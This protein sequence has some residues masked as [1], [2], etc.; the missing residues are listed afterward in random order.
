MPINCFITIPVYRCPER[1]KVP[2][3]NTFS[4]LLRIT[5]RYEL[6][7]VRSQLLEAIRD[8]Y[9]E[10]F[11]G[12]APS[13]SLGE[14]VFSGPTPHPNAVL[15][16]FVQQKVT[17]ALPMA[18]YMATR[19]GLDSLMDR[20]L[21]QS[22]TLSPEI[23]QS[24]IRGF[25]ALC[26]IELKETHRLIFGSKTTHSCSSLKCPS[27]RTA[28]PRGSEAH[29]K[30]VDQITDFSRSGTRVLQVL[31]LADICGDDCGGFCEGCV[32]GWEAEHG[33]VRR[34]VWTALPDV[35]GLTD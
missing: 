31:S 25:T 34:K 13:K 17:S 32:E 15:N 35:F 8:A 33:E 28:G 11:E 18:Y 1:N 19:R 27:H 4:S 21:S 12:L 9:P 10:I 30:V 29:Q 20:R 3:F 5:A 22:A 24:A 16:L 14:G 26:E 7:T 2:D 6:P 23:L